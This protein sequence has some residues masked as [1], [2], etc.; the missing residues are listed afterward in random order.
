VARRLLVAKAAWH[1]G[2]AGGD[3]LGGHGHGTRS[4]RRRSASPLLRRL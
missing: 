1:H 2:G 4:D 3:E